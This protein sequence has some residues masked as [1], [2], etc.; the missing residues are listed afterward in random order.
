[1]LADKCAGQAGAELA[2]MVPMLSATVLVSTAI[3]VEAARTDVKKAEDLADQRRITIEDEDAA[4]LRLVH[5]M[6]VLQNKETKFVGRLHWIFGCTWMWVDTKQETIAAILV[7]AL[8]RLQQLQGNISRLLIFFSIISEH[9][10]ILA[11]KFPQN[12]GFL[13]LM[14]LTGDSKGIEDVGLLSQTFI[15]DALDTKGRFMAM[16]LISQAYAQV[17]LEQILP[18]FEIDG[19]MALSG[20]EQSSG[21]VSAKLRELG[22][23]G[24]SAT[25][26]I[27]SVVTKVSHISESDFLNDC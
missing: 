26:N 1:M 9:V 21:Q 27:R 20:F 19:R 6:K 24:S 14:E 7:Q 8:E 12:D 22:R 16:Q 15:S 18:G 13:L 23:Y 11:E 10:N 5:E 2:S 25:D 4:R 17:S 3:Y